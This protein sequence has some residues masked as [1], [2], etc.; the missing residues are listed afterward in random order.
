MPIDHS[1]ASQTSA[2]S[3]TIAFLGLDFA[4]LDLGSAL[5]HT[6]NLSQKSDFTFIV[7]PN[8]DHVVKLNNNPPTAL[9][10]AYRSA[11]DAADLRL[12]DSRILARLARVMGV[13]IPV[14][15]G[16]DLTA[17]LF[18]RILCEADQVAIIGG[19][20]DTV[21]RLVQLFPKPNFIQHLPPMDIVNNP[22]AIKEIVGFVGHTQAHYTLFAIGSPQS[23]IIAAECKRSGGARGVALCIG[24]SIDF[25]VGDQQRAPHWVQRIG[26]E[27]AYRLAS[28]PRRL[29]R[30][31][32]IEGPRIF[33]ITARWHWSGRPI[34][35]DLGA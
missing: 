35:H 31:Y 16:S 14:V 12:C 11:Y 1:D 6:V 3:Q 28:Q 34:R 26:F 21:A 2:A 22:E 23:E 24:A 33:W 17:A 32:L 27:W 25:L 9:T 7:T 20:S 30:R 10:L 13:Y 19:R 4:N 18:Q 15:T 5:T 29:W 8:V